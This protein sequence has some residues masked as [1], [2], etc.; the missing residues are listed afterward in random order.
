[1]VKQKAITVNIINRNYPPAAGITGESA[2]ELAA[3]LVRKGMIVNIVCVDLQDKGKVNE[4][5]DVNIFSIKTFYSG[6]QKILRL[7]S[8]LFEGYR[9]VR[10]SKKLAPDVTICMTDPPLLN[11]WAALLL[12]KKQKWI[13]WSMDL[14]PEAFAAGNLIRPSNFIYKYIDRIV[15]RRTPS[16]VISLGPC[17]KDYLQKKYKLAASSFTQLP[18]G[19]YEHKNGE[20]ELLQKIPS[21]AAD[22]NKIYLG[23][24]GNLGEAHSLDFLCA[25]VNNLD[26]EKHALILAV[27]GINAKKITDFA[28]GRPGITI[29]PVVQR[30]EMNFI[31]VHLASLKD[32]WTNVCVPSKSVSSVCSGSAF[33]YNGETL[34]DNWVLLENAGWLISGKDMD[35]AAKDFFEQ[36]NSKTITDKKKEAVKIAQNL[37]AMKAQAFDDI[38]T[39]IQG[40][41]NKRTTSQVNLTI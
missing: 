41:C 12:G 15:T 35:T 20:Q 21:W 2:A 1:M 37:I 29:L 32:N 14:Y 9:L 38:S 7:L 18:C 36:L 10:R 30:S 6:K 5:E 26:P 11:V 23:Y 13:L 25:I 31:D 19:I 17:Q 34:S 40:W 27:Y 3:H 39:S 28:S 33:L 22:R 8:S 16:Y 24:C 4:G